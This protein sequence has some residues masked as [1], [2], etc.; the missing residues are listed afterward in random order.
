M[1]HVKQFRDPRDDEFTIDEQTHWLYC[2]VTQTG[3]TTLARWHA[4]TLAKAR[5][6]VLVYDP[7]RTETAGGAWEG[8]TLLEDDREKAFERLAGESD[9]YVF[10][11]EAPDLFGHEYRETH[12]LLRKG[13][14]QGM[15]LRLMSQRPT[16]IPPNVRTQC[17]R[18]FMFRL[19]T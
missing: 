19:A 1:F 11:D 18:L 14:H 8:C 3:K 13:R 4:R 2:G 6:R 12:W 15:Y 9:C 16:M 10:V 5:H 7:V 17:A